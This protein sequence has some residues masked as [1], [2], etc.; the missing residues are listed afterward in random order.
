M[1][2]ELK[3]GMYA[4]ID[5]DKGLITLSLEFKKTPMTV[6]NFVGLAEGSLNKEDE[7]EPFYDGLNFHRVIDN[8]MIQGGCPLGTGTGGPGYKFPDEFDKTLRHTEGGMLSMANAGPGTNGSQFFITHV[9]TPWLDD[10]HTIFGHV[11]EGMDVVNS[12]AQGDKIKT[13]KIIRVGEEAEAFKVTKESFQEY[14]DNASKASRAKKEKEMAGVI[15]AVKKAY[16][17]AI[18]TKS[19]LK[20]IVTKAGDG[21]ASPKMGQQVTVHYEGK[22]LDGTL[23]DSSIKR[24]EPAS[25]GIGQVIEGWNEALMTMTK[26]EKR[27]LII[28]PELG[29]G[30]MGYPGVIPPN[31]YLVFDVELLS[32]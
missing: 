30:E 23:F 15:E 18:E 16:P 25:F 17:D 32:F 1:S 3:D 21:K 24:G 7:G 8:F 5:T 28:P 9:A 26:G 19:G 20:Y 27:T 29:Y 13:V 14:V 4:N 31:A 11:V 6:S 22:L 2:N 10:K 12:I